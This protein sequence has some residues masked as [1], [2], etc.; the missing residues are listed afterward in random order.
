M[1]SA[2][3]VRDEAAG[4]ASVI[5]EMT[6]A[7]FKT[8]AVSD[9][10]EQFVIEA[11]RAAKALAVSLVAER[12]GR[13]VGHVAFSPVTMSDGTP[14]WYGL[15]PVSVLPACQRQGIGTALIEEGLSRVRRLGARGC[16]LVGHPEY[17]GRFG[18]VRAEGLAHEGIP[19]EFFFVLPLAGPVPRGLVHF[20]PAFMAKGPQPA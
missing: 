12:A 16:C 19:P 13:I 11:L 7:A 4:D 20:H 6:E 10:T 18:F 8:L 5:G 2:M 1:Q 15:G 17:Y 14:D 9:Q 3:I